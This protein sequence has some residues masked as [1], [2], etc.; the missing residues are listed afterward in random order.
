M[1]KIINIILVIIWMIVIYS[2]SS[3]NSTVSNEQSGYIVNFI[4]KIFNISNLGLLNYIVRKIAHITEYTVLGF[5][6]E[7]TIKNSNRNSYISL[8]ICLSYA[9]TDELHQS[10]VPGRSPQISDI[11]I[12]SIGSSLGII[13]YT[14]IFKLIAKYKKKINKQ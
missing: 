6:V 11:I 4:S 13:I 2:M 8:I 9:I 1:K 12:D 10:L 7:N 14:I 5:L 3:A